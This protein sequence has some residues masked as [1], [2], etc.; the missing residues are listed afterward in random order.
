MVN[1]SIYRF[2][3]ETEYQLE[4]TISATGSGNTN[5]AVFDNDDSLAVVLSTDNGITW[6]QTNILK[7]W[8]DEDIP[9]NT[10]EYVV[11]DLSIYIHPILRLSPI[12]THNSDPKG[13]DARHQ[14]SRHLK[15]N[16]LLP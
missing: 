12:P 13:M 15:D 4:F 16:I 3:T 5:P 1:L 6:Q 10:G 7:V 11:L 2:G 14:T 9:L 8:T